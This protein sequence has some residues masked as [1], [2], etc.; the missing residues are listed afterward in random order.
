VSEPTTEYVP[1]QVIADTLLAALTRERK[2]A[3]IYGEDDLREVI[4][5]LTSQPGR[6]AR[7][8]RDDMVK[9]RDAAFGRGAQTGGAR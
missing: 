4:D 6:K 2:V 5:A 8:L 7:E 3:V 1:R 9:L